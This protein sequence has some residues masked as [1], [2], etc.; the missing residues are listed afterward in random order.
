MRIGNL[1]SRL[2]ALEKRQPDPTK[3]RKTPLP[4]WLVEDFRKQGLRIDAS[5]LPVFK[6]SQAVMEA[7]P[8]E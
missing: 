4:D 1:Y 6:N 5:G 7:T 8:C 2:R 3:T